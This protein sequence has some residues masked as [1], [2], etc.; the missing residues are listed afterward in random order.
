MVSG[1]AGILQSWGLKLFFDTPSEIISEYSFIPERFDL[2][3]NY[4]NPFN[5]STTIKWQQP[6]TGLVTLKIYDVLGREVTTLITEELTAGEHKTIFDAS[7]FSSGIYFYQIKAGD[8]IQ[9]KKMI[10]IK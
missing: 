1:N 4:P 5:P 9:T 6:E 2:Y 8:F 7:G 10:L 3:Q